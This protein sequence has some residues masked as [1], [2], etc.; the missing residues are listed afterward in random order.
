MRETALLLCIV[1]LG[2]LLAFVGYEAGGASERL[3]AA[4]AELGL[5]KAEAKRQEAR[6]KKQARL[7]AIADRAREL[8]KLASE[9]GMSSEED[10][11][12]QYVIEYSQSIRLPDLA[13]ELSQTRSQ[14]GRLF[15]PHRVLLQELEADHS[16]ST[17]PAGVTHELRLEGRALLV[18]GEPRAVAE[19]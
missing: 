15:V 17:Q 4:R 16:R 6:A 3:A 5:R 7:D 14:P 19:K 1:L 10:A 18:H 13:A 2:G 9:L 11:G 8:T 12:R